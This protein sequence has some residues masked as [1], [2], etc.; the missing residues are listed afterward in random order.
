MNTIFCKHPNLKPSAIVCPDCEFLRL[1]VCQAPP[2]QCP[3]CGS[4]NLDC[5]HGVLCRDCGY[6]G[7][8]SAAPDKFTLQL[9]RKQVFSWIKEQLSNHPEK[10]STAANFGWPQNISDKQLIWL[11]TFLDEPTEKY[12]EEVAAIVAARKLSK[13][14]GDQKIETTGA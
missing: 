7:W 5:K 8:W 14:M 13:E 1:P 4:S 9:H 12:K 2:E 11:A 10:Q 3:E 6:H